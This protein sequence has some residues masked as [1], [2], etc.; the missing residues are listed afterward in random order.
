MKLKWNEQDITSL[1]QSVTWGGSAFQVARTLDFEVA[2]SP[3]DNN[4]K[5]P[6]IKVGDRVKLYDDKNR[7]LINAMVY[8][9]E[10]ISENGVISYSCMDDMKRLIKSTCTYNF[11][12]T[13]PE[14]IARKLCQDLNIAVGNVAVTNINIK[15]LLVD[16]SGF[17]DTIMMAYTKAYKA[18]S[19]KYMPIMTNQKFNIIEKGE[20]VADFVLNDKINIISSSYSESIENMVNKVKIYDGNGK[21]IGEVVNKDWINKFGIFQEVYEKEDGI[22]AT[23]VSKAL[24]SGIESTASIEALGN[25]ECI[26]GFGV[27][28]KDSITGL[29]GVFWIDSDSHTWQDGVHTMTLELAFKNLMEIIE[30]QTE[31]KSSN[32]WDGSTVYLGANSTKYHSKN[33]C[34]NIKNVKSMTQD[35]AIKQG[36]SKCS[37]CF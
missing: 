5:D 29:T 23:A 25:V 34:S 13:T 4:I 17:Y 9:R 10:R 12:N 7:L 28:V 15:T 37:K 16:S 20:I 32:K 31:V 2:Y 1:V 35:Q 26:A 19:K 33:T 8:T 36:Y 14:R 21:Q 11:K 24:L 6:N 18:N 22:N 3:L 30:D 27:K